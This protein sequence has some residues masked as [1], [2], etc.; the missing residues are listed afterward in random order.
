M[1]IVRGCEIPELLYFSVEDR[2]WLAPERG[3]AVLLG[4]AAPGCVA[5]GEIVS[6]TP[7]KSGTA[8][9]R[10]MSCGTLESA[11]WVEPARCPIAGTIIEINALA[12][13]HPLVINRDPYGSGWLVR[14]APEDWERDSAG[15]VSGAAA[16]AAFDAALQELGTHASA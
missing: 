11:R 2:V 1:A 5:L 3:G 9:R 4:L 16:L 10:G 8:L 14:I 13:E 6:F 15:L 7:R 12:V